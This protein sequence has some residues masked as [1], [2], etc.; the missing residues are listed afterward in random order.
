MK[1]YTKISQ[2]ETITVEAYLNRTG[3]QSPYFSITGEIR[4][5]RVR[6]DNGIIACGCLHE[7]IL[8]TWPDLAD[9]V[10]MHLSDIDGQPMHAEANALYWA[11]GALSARHG[12]DMPVYHGSNGSSAKTPEECREI[13]ARHLRL[14][15]SEPAELLDMIAAAIV[16]TESDG[17]TDP[18]KRGKFAMRT[19]CELLRP[20]WKAEADAAILKYSLEVKTR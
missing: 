8:K 12:L 9:L 7:D 1:R 15:G 4:D 17:P 11:N 14:S 2:Y 10:A 20:R 18:Q 19:Y 16:R 6:R 3:Q 13:L 5:S